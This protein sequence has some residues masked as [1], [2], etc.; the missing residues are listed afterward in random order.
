MELCTY[1][2]NL[3]CPSE[4]CKLTFLSNEE[5]VSHQNLFPEEH[6]KCKE[7]SHIF[8]SKT[9]FLGHAALDHEENHLVP[10]QTSPQTNGTAD[11]NTGNRA[12]VSESVHLSLDQNHMVSPPEQHV[13]TS[14]TKKTSQLTSERN[15]QWADI[16]TSMPV[17]DYEQIQSCLDGLEIKEEANRPF[18]CPIC[19]KR[20]Q[21]QSQWDIHLRSHTGEKPFKCSECGMRFGKKS[22]LDTHT[23]VH[24][25][26]KP[27]Q[28]SKCGVTFRHKNNLNTHMRV[29]TGVKPFAC[30]VC[31]KTFAEKSQEKRHSLVHTTG[32]KKHQCGQCGKKFLRKHDLTRHE[33]GYCPKG[34]DTQE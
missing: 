30:Q 23:R 4:W 27:Y 2:N 26:T 28:C 33:R 12:L 18:E 10:Q 3:Q 25:K 31:G 21:W 9:E 13:D 34:Q 8:G 14:Y 1:E 5:L 24:T 17:L 22:N 15:L 11:T 19:D 6:F 20:F 29:H 32:E 16:D 7:C